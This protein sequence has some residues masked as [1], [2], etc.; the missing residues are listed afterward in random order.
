M[1]LVHL[2]YAVEVEKTK[3]ITKAA[4]NLF[5]GQPNLSRAIRELEETTGL[6]IFKRTSR[7]VTP[8]EKGA[9][10]LNY[11]KK[12][13]DQVYE[14]E[15]LY[16]PDKD[17]MLSFSLSFPHAAYITYALGKM[18]LK[19]DLSRSIEINYEETNNTQTVENILESNCNLGI[20]RY[21]SIQDKYYRKLFREKKLKTKQICEYEPVVLMSRLHH[22]SDS[23][24]IS[25]RDLTEYIEIVAGS[26][27]ESTSVLNNCNNVKPE[28]FSDKQ[29]IVEKGSQLDLLAVLPTS[30]MWSSPAPL[31][32]ISKYSLVQKACSDLKDKYQDVLIY[33]S[34]Y[35]LKEL[36]KVFIE[37]L[38]KSKNE[39]IPLPSAF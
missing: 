23:Q 1:N 17:N 30:Y 16:Q 13:L 39:T 29:I 10:F 12:I 9:E 36:D 14:I 37:Q 20:I 38:E 24:T 3:S 8:T 25:S 4:E 11:S 27:S 18:A 28:R 5:M 32:Y 6:K 21:Q 15:K 35:Q 26:C 2:K 31:E 33:R 34:D 7:G 22:L 19:L